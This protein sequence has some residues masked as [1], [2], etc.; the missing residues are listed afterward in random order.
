MNFLV[1]KKNISY[2]LFG[3]FFLYQMFGVMIHKQYGFGFFYWPVQLYLMFIISFFYF[4]IRL[5][6]VKKVI[7]NINIITIYFFI[8][9]TF[10]LMYYFNDNLASYLSQNEVLQIIFEETFIWFFIAIV[11]ATL[12]K[13]LID[14]LNVKSMFLILFLLFLFFFAYIYKLNQNFGADF[15]RIFIVGANFPTIFIDKF[16]SDS[17]YV[18]GFH[19]YFSPLFAIFILVFII[20]L[21]ELNKFKLSYLL[22]F[23]A[24]Y[25]LFLASGRGSLLVF[26]FV[27][28]FFVFPKRFLF[29]SIGLFILFIV[30]LVNSDFMML[31]QEQNERLHDILTFN[32]LEDNSSLGRLNQLNLNM[33]YIH[34]NWIVGGLRSYYTI[35]G[36]GEYIHNVLSVLQEY[37]IIPFIFIILF[38]LQGLYLVFKVKSTDIYIKIAKAVFIYMLIECLLFKYVHEIKILIPM[39]IT[40]YILNSSKKAQHVI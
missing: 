27:S 8:L 25:I 35:L 33:G 40:Y 11:M 22:F 39:I 7:S 36:E 4:F 31:L 13:T 10:Q 15:I 29:L 5:D 34:N 2:F 32:F 14:K 24:I 26:I 38:F 16:L 12:F 20:K 37:G 17:G 21:Q 19:L 28:L 3:L 9:I 18:R 6:E 1:N 30:F 23:I